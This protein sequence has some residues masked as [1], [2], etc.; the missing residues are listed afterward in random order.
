M[1]PLETLIDEIRAV[2]AGLKECSVASEEIDRETMVLRQKASDLLG[3]KAML[4]RILKEHIEDGI[5]IVHAKLSAGGSP[6]TNFISEQGLAFKYLD[7][8]DSE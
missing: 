4:E 6:K 1:T 8:Q 7:K 3:R 2:N 5:D